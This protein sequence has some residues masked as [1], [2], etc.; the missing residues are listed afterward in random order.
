M[1]AARFWRVVGLAARDGGDLELSALHLYSTG[2]RVDGSATLFVTK[3]PVAG[4]LTALQDDDT[5]TACRF[6]AQAVRAQGFALAWDFGGS[7]ADVV[8]LRFGA[9]DNIGLFIAA[10]TL[11]SS[12]DGLQWATVETTVGRYAWP[13][14]RAMTVVT[15]GSFVEV[16]SETFATGIPGGFATTLLDAGTLGITYDAANGAVILDATGYNTAWM[17]NMPDAQL[18][19]KLEFDIEIITPTYGNGP[20]IGLVLTGGPELLQNNVSPGGTLFASVRSNSAVALGQYE[21]LASTGLT[22]AAPS[23]GRALWTYSSVPKATGGRDYGFAV[24]GTDVLVSHSQ[25]PATAMLKTGLFLRSCKVR[26]HGVRGF[27]LVA[28]GSEVRPPRT[29][30]NRAQ[31]VASFPAGV[32]SIRSAAALKTARDVEFGGSGTVYGTTKTKGTPNQPTM[33]RVVLLH[34]RSKLPVRE[35][36]SDPVTGN[37][38]FA[39][40]DTNQQFITLAEDAAG[41]F[42][43]VAANRLTPEVLP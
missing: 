10:L 26:L 31:I 16:W 5:G 27:A 14:P 4:A 23:T 12:S 28:A 3:P 34:Q 19:V 29:V 20:A 35:T 30:P 36:W 41:N 21:V 40:I 18:G 2:G 7:P 15:S 33:A 8:G 22:S 38:A 42:R 9:A 1:A 17:F 43:P 24:D 39:G 6:S 11:Q 25:T 13:G 32:S 37:F